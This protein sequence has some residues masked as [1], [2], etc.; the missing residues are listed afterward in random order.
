MVEDHNH[1]NNIKLLW[2]KVVSL[3]VSIF[4]WRIFFNRVPTKDN[5]A[6]RH[7]LAN[8]DHLISNWLG[9]TTTFHASSLSAYSVLWHGDFRIESGSLSTFSSFMLFG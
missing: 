4:A 8:N 5:L 7:V 1:R 3:K 6:E 9:F 2:L